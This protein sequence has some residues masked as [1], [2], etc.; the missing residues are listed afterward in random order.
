M[1]LHDD[2]YAEV[3][4]AYAMPG[5]ILIYK[6][7]DGDITHVVVSN[8]PDLMSGSSNIHVLSQWGSDGE[9]LHDYRD[10]P[11]LLGNPL[12]SIVKSEK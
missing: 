2:G 7:T 9:Y 10:V 11:H 1:I 8:V 4:E 12:S 3:L 5:D 6:D